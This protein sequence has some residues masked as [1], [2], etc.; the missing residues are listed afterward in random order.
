MKILLA[1][2]DSK[3][4][5]AAAQAL[6]GQFQP[7]NT[8]I[9]VLHAVDVSLGDYQSQDVFEGAHSTKVGYAKELVSRYEKKL[10]EAG[11][12]TTTVV[13]NGLPQACIVDF[14]ENWKPDFIFLGSHGRR[15]WKRLALGSVSEAVAHKAHSSVVI[16]RPPATVH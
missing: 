7:A 5:E 2:D 10:K 8:E 1:V 3:Y 14:A 4:S 6:M 16:V 12:A 11:Y 9:C 13:E 15:G